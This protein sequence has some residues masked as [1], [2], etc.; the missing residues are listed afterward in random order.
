MRRSTFRIT[1]LVAAV[2]VCLCA[3]SAAGQKA[4][5][6][7]QTD[8]READ[9][10]K[11]GAG[12]PFARFL[13]PPELIMQHQSEIGLTDAQRTTITTAIQQAQGRFV[14]AQFKISGEGEK[15]GRLLQG[16]SI[17]EAQAVEQVDR[18]LS[19]ERDVKRAQVGLLVRLKN[20]L[21]PQ[22]QARL[23]QLR[24]SRE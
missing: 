19:L 2:A 23:A 14:E 12:D 5:A 9:G 21:T 4:I 6:G 11:Q 1:A 7:A 24:Q 3:H 10:Q 8:R 18:I 22:Q 16:V 15:L 20:A 13:F 17:D